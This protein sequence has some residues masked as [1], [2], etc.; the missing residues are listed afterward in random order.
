[1]RGLAVL[2]LL[3]CASIGHAEERVQEIIV[4]GLL[5][6]SDDTYRTTRVEVGPLGDR[7]LLDTPY[8]I[9]VVPVNLA[10]NQQLQNV[11][12]LFRYIPS[13][14]GE[15]IRPQSR[16]LQAGVVQ[17]T[18]ID[19]LNI[20]AT[21]DYAIEQFERIEVLN[22]L[23]GALYG[24][25]SPAGTFNYVFKRPT[26][27]ALTALKF[28]YTSEG[29]ILAHADVS[30][31][32]GPDGL[33]GARINLLSQN[34]ESYAE[35][36]NMRRRLASASFDLR[37]AEGTRLEVNSSYYRYTA[38]GFPGTFALASG[39]TYPDPTPDPKQ[40]G[41]GYRWAGD[42]NTIFLASG[43][44]FQT[45]GSDWQL[46]AGLLYMS[47]DRAS[48]V[49][50]L[51]LTDNAGAYRAT[52]VTTTFALD[53]VLSNHATLRGKLVT[54]GVSHDLFVGTTGFL[55]KR[56]TP[57][58]TGAITLGTGNLA[59]PAIFAQPALP[60]FKFRFHAQT[61]QQQA[62]TFGDTLGIGE[63]V[64]VL[65]AASQSW[66]EARNIN[67]TGT[68]TSR[69]KDNGFSPTASLMVKP[70]GNMTAYVTYAS[71]LQQGD[72]A[73]STA[74]NAGEALAPYRSEQ[75][76]VGYKLDLGKV[77]LALA[78]F[79]IERPYAFVGTDNVF[80][81]Q[82]RQRNRGIELTANGRLTQHLN[83]FAGLS[84]L[85]PKLF[86]TGSA[87]TDGKRILGLSKLAFNLLA[88]Y[89]LPMLPELTVSADVAHVSERPGNNANTNMVD[90]YTTV[91]LGLRYQMDL[92]GQALAFR[93]AVDNLF[94]ERYW[95][96]IAPTG[97]N[98]YN[99]AG[100]GIGTLGAPRSVRLQVQVAL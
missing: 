44:L 8:S 73:P 20:A 25:A 83:I 46:N 89:R 1:M 45:I 12:E 95:A 100:N 34:G 9:S 24:P 80:R 21:T 70:R 55:W 52:T 58:N 64:S 29:N 19:G 90:G 88:E 2:P 26:E 48:T 13:V 27:R 65:L 33:F 39:V 61:T 67:R 94:D 35:A 60:D 75:W 18:R 91:D 38:T 87:L 7:S 71:S 15:N 62:I 41:L 23:A 54:G 49:P 63:H 42:D 53:R 36:S 40:A 79:Q 56:Y 32:V 5:P 57:F 85:D 47:N 92:N 22:G 17:N 81:E 98:G 93:L 11:R 77:Q 50:T 99:A 96:N 10:E 59:N 97:Q 6:A 74:A 43:R 84:L 4:N 51:T 16:G 69:Y 28:G 82:G 72:A 66:I 14:Q 30:R 76:E 37:P 3:G 86:D 31:R 68:V 78:G